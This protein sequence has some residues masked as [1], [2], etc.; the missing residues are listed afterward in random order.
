MEPLVVLSAAGNALQFLQFSSQIVCKGHRLYKSVH[1][2]LEKNLDVEAVT[3]ALKDL[4]LKLQISLADYDCK[5]E[6]IVALKDLCGKCDKISNSLCSHLEALKVKGPRNRKWK[7][8]RQALKS[9]W[10]KDEIDAM[11]ASLESYRNQL[12]LQLVA[13]IM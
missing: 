11:A 13:S 9:V 10:C 3:T 2:A 1:G 7:S 4:S 6:S 5:P 8:C 12:M